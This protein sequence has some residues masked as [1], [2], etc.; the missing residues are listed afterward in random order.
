MTAE[1]AT[2]LVA[3][4]TVLLLAYNSWL[5]T[6]ELERIRTRHARLTRRVWIL[7]GKPR[8]DA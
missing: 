4:V 7:E 8:G 1:L 2:Q 6:R 5:T 3:S